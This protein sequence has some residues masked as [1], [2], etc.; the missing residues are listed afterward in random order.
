[1]L[2]RVAKWA[3]EAQASLHKHT[4][5]AVSPQTSLQANNI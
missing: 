2:E 3:A 1:M 5:L 4:G